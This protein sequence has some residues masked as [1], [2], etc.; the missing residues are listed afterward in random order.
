MAEKSTGFSYSFELRQPNVPLKEIAEKIKNL[1]EPVVVVFFDYDL[2]SGY[3][4]IESIVNNSVEFV[5]SEEGHP[6]LKSYQEEKIKESFADKKNIVIRFKPSA[7]RYSSDLND[8]LK[9][10]G[11]KTIIGVKMRCSG[12]KSN[13]ISWLYDKGFDWIISYDID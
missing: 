5:I 6:S 3:Y 10:L 1:E 12:L 8:T 7:N 9:W 11:A 2:L 13:S 4:A